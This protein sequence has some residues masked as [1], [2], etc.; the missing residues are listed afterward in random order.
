MLLLF[1]L[2]KCFKISKT[3]FSLCTQ[4]VCVH[5]YIVICIKIIFQSY[6]WIHI[7]KNCV[8]SDTSKRNVGWLDTKFLISSIIESVCH[9][10]SLIL[11]SFQRHW[12]QC[13]LLLKCLG[14]LCDQWMDNPNAERSVRPHVL[15]YTE[16]VIAVR[17]H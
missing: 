2:L 13:S 14:V 17:K 12:C 6:W 8:C 7:C 3:S 10:N 15:C 4:N 16:K 11:I 1:C 5:K 9:A